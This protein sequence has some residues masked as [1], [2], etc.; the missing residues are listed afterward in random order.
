MGASHSWIINK[1]KPCRVTISHAIH[2]GRVKLTVDGVTVFE[3]SDSHALWDTGFEHELSIHDLNCHLRVAFPD[4][5]PRYELWVNG[6]L[7]SEADREAI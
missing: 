3:Q 4:G 7:H 6:K 2:S 1:S 5:R